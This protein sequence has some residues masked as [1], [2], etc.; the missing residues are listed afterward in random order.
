MDSHIAKEYWEYF[1]GLAGKINTIKDT[2]GAVTGSPRQAFR[3]SYSEEML[4]D[5]IIALLSLA[6]ERKMNIG[7][8]MKNRLQK[9]LNGN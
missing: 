3:D 7:T 6:A 8:T 1:D 9:I 2:V 5:A 4:A